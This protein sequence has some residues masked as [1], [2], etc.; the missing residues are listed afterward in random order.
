[1]SMSPVTYINLTP[2][3]R[4]VPW[5]FSV[6]WLQSRW[7]L[8]TNLIPAYRYTINRESVSEVYSVKAEIY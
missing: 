7:K 6:K 4:V 5:F 3:N 2:H 1:M 8:I